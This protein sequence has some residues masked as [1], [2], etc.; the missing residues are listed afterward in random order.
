MLIH[1]IYMNPVNIIPILIPTP[2]IYGVVSLAV[3]RECY[4]KLKYEAGNWTNLSRHAL[5]Y[6]K[7]IRWIGTFFAIIQFLSK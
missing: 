5:L 1:L 6:T 7:G 3:F 2:F 4:E